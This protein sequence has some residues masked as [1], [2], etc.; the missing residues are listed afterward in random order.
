MLLTF[1]LTETAAINGT[2][3]VLF[4]IHFLENLI[5]VTVIVVVV[6]VVYALIYENANESRNKGLEGIK[7]FYLS[8]RDFCYY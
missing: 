8:K 7:Q 5:I 6:V 3:S 2:E 1:F 4:S